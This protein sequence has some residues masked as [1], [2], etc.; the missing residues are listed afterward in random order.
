MS[1]QG[2]TALADR[3]EGE[4]SVVIPTH[5]RHATL[6]RAIRSAIIQGPDVKEIIVV[7]DNREEEDRA[8]VLRIIERMNDPRVVHLLNEGR[9]GGAASRNVALRRARGSL[10]A[11]LDDDD[12]WL[13]GKIAAQKA[14]MRPGIVGVDCGYVERDDAWGLLFEVHGDGRAKTQAELLAGYCPT[15]T[16]LVMVARDVAVRA[17]GFDEEIDSFEDYDLWLRCA[18]EGRFATLPQ[19]KCVYLQHSGARLS[20]ALEVRLKGLDGFLERWGSRLGGDREVEA[21]R[22][23]WRLVAHSTN[24]RRA[25]PTDRRASLRHALDALRVDPARRAGWQAVAFA[26]MGFPLAR[27]LSRARHAAPLSGATV[28]ALRVLEAAVRADAG[29]KA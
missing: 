1:A 10:V 16:S 21:F 28:E 3:G 27:R 20:V 11:F 29:G 26:L 12:A 2:E 6:P 18:A 13:P 15:S 7:D 25:L 19:P 23:R 5:R 14:L 24:A 4:V 22:R 17:G 8:Q 9:R